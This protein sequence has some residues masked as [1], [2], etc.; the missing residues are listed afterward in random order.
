LL[1]SAETLKDKSALSLFA[2]WIRKQCPSTRCIRR[3]GFGYI[4]RF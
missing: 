3:N 4:E 1:E 2:L